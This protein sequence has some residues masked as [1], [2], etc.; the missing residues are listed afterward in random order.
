MTRFAVWAPDAGELEMVVGGSQYPLEKEPSG[1]WST[2][3]ADAGHGTDYAF[4]VDGGD[5]T[6]DP[7]SLWQPQRGAR[8]VPGIRPHASPLGR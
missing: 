6:P 2:D 4:R 5:P 8:A 3:I 1:W 7:R